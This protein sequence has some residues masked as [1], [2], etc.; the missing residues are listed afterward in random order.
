MGWSP[1]ADR[2]EKG[3]VLGSFVLY[4]ALLSLGSFT[5]FLSLGLSHSKPCVVPAVQLLLLHISRLPA[6]R[7]LP[8]PPVSPANVHTSFNP[9][10][11]AFFSG[12]FPTLYF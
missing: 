9:Q 8:T 1:G 2:A 6:W 3:S 5:M 12:A 7:G 4:P 10:L 11:T